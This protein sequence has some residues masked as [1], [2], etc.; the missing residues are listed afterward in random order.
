MWSCSGLLSSAET[1][2]FSTIVPAS[3]NDVGIDRPT[4]HKPGLM[5]D[6]KHGYRFQISPEHSSRLKH[7]R[8]IHTLPL[9][10][11][12]SQA[13]IANTHGL[14]AQWLTIYAIGDAQ[15]R[16]RWSRRADT[17]SII[18]KAENRRWVPLNMWS[19]QHIGLYGYRDADLSWDDV[20]SVLR[21][22]LVVPRV[23]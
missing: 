4:A 22:R 23:K 17:H 8:Y 13:Y 7:L 21:L 3:M 19:W 10:Q 14:N 11:C 9:V 20:L 12:I 2:R 6:H 15:P 1:V 16:F 5:D 18:G